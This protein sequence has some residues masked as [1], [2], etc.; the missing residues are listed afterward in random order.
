MAHR[1]RPKRQH[2]KRGGLDYGTPRQAQTSALQAGRPGLR[3]TEIGPN[4]STPSGEAW[5]TAHQSRP[6]RQHS[7]RG[8]LGCSTPRQ[9]HTPALQV[10]RPGLRHTEAG[11]NVSTPSGEAWI[12]A[13]RDRP[14][15]QHS[16]RGGL[17][18][19]TPRQAQTPALQAR[20]PGLRHTEAGP[21]VSTP[22]GEAWVAAH[23]GRPK[24]QHSKRGGLDYGTPWQ[25]QAS[26]LRARRP[27]LRPAATG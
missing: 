17:G 19:S 25:A 26:A 14:K 20:R 10:G 8:G 22:S 12:V 4:V 24:R 2:F 11:P 27:G 1:G 3:H 15:R 13:H 18:C 23:R 9:A 21:N 6:K 16:K 5:I 7:K